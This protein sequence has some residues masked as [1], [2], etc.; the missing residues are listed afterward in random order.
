R[1]PHQAKALGHLDLAIQFASPGTANSPTAPRLGLAIFDPRSKGASQRRLCAKKRE[2]FVD[3]STP[4]TDT[5]AGK[6]CRVLLP[7][8]SHTRSNVS[9]AA[10]ARHYSVL[11]ADRT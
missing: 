7:E 8:N 1:R 4:T 10:N 3:G 11:T 2:D 5:A 6:A 9:T